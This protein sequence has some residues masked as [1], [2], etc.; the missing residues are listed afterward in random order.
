MGDRERVELNH[1]ERAPAKGAGG[2]T[3]GA[4]LSRRSF[5]GVVGSSSASLAL[6]GLGTIGTSATLAGCSE[7]EA[8]SVA[9]GLGPLTPYQRRLAAKDIRHA[10]AGMA[11]GIAPEAHVSNGDE[12]RYLGD[13]AFQNPIAN[14]SKTLPHD[15]TTG[16]VDPAAYRM[17]LAALETGDPADFNAIPNAAGP[18]PPLPDGRRLVNPEAGLAFD[19]E[20][21]DGQVFSMPPAPAFRSAEAAGELVECYWMALLRDVHFSD[22]G[23]DAT[24]GDAVTDLNALS[25][26]RGPK[27][28]GSVTTGTLFRGDQPGCLAGPYLSQFLWLPVPYGAI[29]VEQRILTTIADADYM[30][31]WASWLDVQDGAFPEL[32]DLD[33]SARY[34]RNLRDLS[35]Y[36]HIDA[37]F[38][39]YLNAAIILLGASGYRVGSEA[40]TDPGNPYFGANPSP[41]QCG[42]GTFGG[43]HVLSLVAAVAS[44]ALHAILYCKW[45]VHRRLRPEAFAGRLEAERRGALVLGS[46]IHDDL[47]NSDALAAI[48]AHNESIN[49]MGNGT[50]LLPQAFPEGSPA[51]PSYGAGHATVAGACGTILKAFFD[52]DEKIVDLPALDNARFN[53]TPVVAKADGTDLVAYLGSDAGDLTVGGEIDKLIANIAIGRNGAG[54]HYR[55]DYA[56]S[57]ALGEKLAIQL[58]REQKLTFNEGHSYTFTRFNGEK[59]TI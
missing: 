34:I 41:K 18:N 8:Q 53:N 46:E 17:L 38:Q 49:G 3:G 47:R 51:H 21:P 28:A 30:T 15:A 45:Y 19:L 24:A 25:D 11:W 42:F 10:A 36:V 39:A 1:K 26:F 29:E 59:I 55:S 33:P 12:D 4:R 20:G 43:A 7:S 23:S 13:P 6:G 44:R 37:L 16:L 48:F 32:A 54:V 57:I 50:Y 5:L 58:L 2:S 31:G 52:E 56:D 14:F 27:D 9:D 22:W 35:A 40:R